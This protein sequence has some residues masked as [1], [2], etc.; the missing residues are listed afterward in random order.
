MQ[1]DHNLASKPPS[2]EA[3]KDFHDRAFGAEVPNVKVCEFRFA[4]L[5]DSGNL[6]LIISINPEG[7]QWQNEMN[8][9]FSTGRQ[10][11]SKFT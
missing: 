10:G 3:V 9:T 2:L 1:G 8:C 4:D 11:D 5:R 7:R 6:S